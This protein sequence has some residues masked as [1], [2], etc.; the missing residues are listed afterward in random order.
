ML[1]EQAEST[2]YSSHIQREQLQGRWF[3]QKGRPGCLCKHSYDPLSKWLCYMA[4]LYPSPMIYIFHTGF[5]IFVFVFNPHFWYSLQFLSMFSATMEDLLSILASIRP[6]IIFCFSP[7]AE[8]SIQ[9][10]AGRYGA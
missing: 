9:Y 3:I 2:S 5:Y 7:T 6:Y 8:F 1:M 10:H 4:E